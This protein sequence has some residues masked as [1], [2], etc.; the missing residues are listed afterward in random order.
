MRH[1]HMPTP[2]Q[3]IRLLDLGLT[4][5]VRTQ[6]VYHA[7]AE[8]MRTGSPDTVIVCRPRTPYVCLG[9]HQAYA[10]T[11]DRVAV[12]RRRLPVFRRR[13]GGGATYLDSNQVFYQCIVH[14]TRVPVMVS[15][16]YRQMLA[17]PVSALQ[18]FGLRARLYDMNEIEV[19]GKRIAGIGG[20]RIGEAAVVVGNVLGD[21]DFLAMAE[22]WRVPSA[23]F[24]E[25]A[26]ETMRERIT[27]LREYALMD[28][29]A[30]QKL[31]LEEFAV[32]FGRPIEP[33]ELTSEEEDRSKEIAE[34]QTSAEY[35][36][37]HSNTPSA[38]PMRMLKIS[39]RAWIHAAAA[40]IDGY[41]VRASFRVCDDV[42]EM[43]K[44]ESSPRA[45][46][47]AVEQG[48][49]GIPLQAWEEQTRS[50]MQSAQEL[51]TPA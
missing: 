15:D 27:T 4:D 10:A 51:C 21:F 5:W 34:R 38:E 39:A 32:S 26:L 45:D 14:H 42:I 3:S 41:T 31:L 20:G 25:L 28:L 6:S 19:D 33:G 47:H 11:L 24:R 17:A 8:L 30:F 36:N 22:V 49:R 9:Y 16:V 1:H 46:W 50:L 12:E 13:L 7:V 37:L 40:E 43:A 48:L 29:D 35:L 44:L 18:R 2:R 23:S